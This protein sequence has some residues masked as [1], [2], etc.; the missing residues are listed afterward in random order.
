MR[1]ALEANEVASHGQDNDPWMDIEELAARLRRS[2]QTLYVWRMK[3]IGPPGTLI[4]NKVL[5]RRTAV[6]QW[7]RQQEREQAGSAA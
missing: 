3:G 4:G 5:Y 6:D 2:R 1:F 7:E